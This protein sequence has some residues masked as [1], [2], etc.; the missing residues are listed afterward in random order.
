MRKPLHVLLV[1]DSNLDAQLIQEELRHHDFE[2]QCE[3]VETEPGFRS[4]LAAASWDV[5][6]ADY[7]LPR[8]SAIEAL[9]IVQETRLDVPF[10]IV[11]GTIG[12]DVAVAA[13]KAGAHD[14]VMKGKLARLIPAVERELRDAEVRH[15]RVQAEEDLRFQAHLI[16]AV[17]QAIVAT[18]AGGK[19]TYWNRPAEVLY[20]WTAEEALGR[21]LKALVLP[22]GP[23]A[24]SMVWA[25]L[26]KGRSWFGET[27]V[28]RRDSTALTALV[29]SSPVF[30]ASGKIA[31]VIQVA[32]DVTERKQAELQLADS[33]EQ[34]RA[35]AAK[36]QSV[37]EEERKELSRDIH[38]E[39]GQVLTGLKMELAWMRSRLSAS[40]PI[41]HQALLDKI[42]LLGSQI[43]SSADRI[44][45][46]C[47]ELRPGIL[48][49]LG[50]VAAIEWQAREFYKRTG[51]EC[52]LRSQAADPPLGPDQ[53][54]AVFRIF[55]EI[56]T[57][58]ARHAKA[59]R[60]TVNLTQSQTVLLLEARDNGRGIRPEDL[61]AA[62]SLGLLGMRERAMA[63]GGSIEF[64]GR[65]GAGT[66]VELRVPFKK[67]SSAKTQSTKTAL[68]KSRARQ[69]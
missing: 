68:R 13:M 32:T 11:S 14:Y 27:K 30:D 59:S 51:I 53:N 1:E 66:K 50:L 18:N 16:D 46:L 19:V 10:I 63:L 61:T 24:H 7:R 6:I 43:D 62:K 41:P 38:D 17:G 65:P 56:L 60:V 21:D 57:N 36:L 9:R 58:V 49:D 35:L 34:L 20:G 44:R 22:D 40:G 45:K 55:Q 23:A 42:S 4:Q 2:L 28:R 8:F 48:D 33:R 3:R 54:T 26:R 52:R 64:S 15:A 12:E 25:E 29:T 5:I 47:A 69:K 37:R 31:G 39:L 67:T